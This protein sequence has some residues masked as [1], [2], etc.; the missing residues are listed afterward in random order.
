MCRPTEDELFEGIK[1]LKNNKA[2]GQDGKCAELIK[3]GD[4]ELWEEI[5]K[6]V[7]T[8]WISEKMPEDWN[9]SVICPIYKKRG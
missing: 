7:Q 2:P 9:I 8:I 6:L 5:H 1:N 3:N 4:M